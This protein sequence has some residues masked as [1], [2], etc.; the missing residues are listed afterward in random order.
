MSPVY[1][2]RNAFMC[3]AG[4]TRMP[5]SKCI[6]HGITAAGDSCYSSGVQRNLGRAQLA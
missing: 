5:R 2:D 1:C 3:M 4:A 6:L